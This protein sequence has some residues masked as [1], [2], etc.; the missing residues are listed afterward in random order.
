MRRL[1]ALSM[2]VPL[3][4][5]SFLAPTTQRITI[6]VSHPDAEIIVDGET[7]GRGHVECDLQRGVNHTFMAKMGDRVGHSGLAAG[8]RS[9][10][11]KIDNFFGIFLIVPLFGLLAPGSYE[12]RTNHVSITLPNVTVVEGS[13]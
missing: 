11:G 5:C 3:C 13:K 1:I 10:I 6:T 7:V 8:N 4:G 12:F 2:L 9:T